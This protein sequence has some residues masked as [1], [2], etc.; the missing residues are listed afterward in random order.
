MQKNALQTLFWIVDEESPISWFIFWH[1]HCQQ[2]SVDIVTVNEIIFRKYWNKVLKKF[3]FSI[4]I[5]S[6]FGIWAEK[7]FLLEPWCRNL[8]LLFDKHKSLTWSLSSSCLNSDSSNEVEI[9]KTRSVTISCSSCELL[10]SSLCKL[11]KPENT[12]MGTSVQW[13]TGLRADGISG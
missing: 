3:C 13:S 10:E 12:E 7:S 5:E 6:N 4:S 1:T 9:W 8:W 11:G 2:I